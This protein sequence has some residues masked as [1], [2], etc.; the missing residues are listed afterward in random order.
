MNAAF[1]FAT[2]AI[3][4]A[5]TVVFLFTQE[6]SAWETMISLLVLTGFLS[7][8]FRLEKIRRKIDG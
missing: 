1:S 7:V 5:L 2:W 3:M 8:H 4:T 6:L